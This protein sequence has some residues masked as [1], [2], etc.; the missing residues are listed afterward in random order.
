MTLILF[1]SPN[2][3]LWSRILVMNWIINRVNK[4]L[5]QCP[6]YTKFS[7][8]HAQMMGLP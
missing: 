4:F 2:R 1:V 6:S 5:A 8:I 3:D 7:S